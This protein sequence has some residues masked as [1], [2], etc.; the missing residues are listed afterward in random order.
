MS[1]VFHCIK[2]HLF[3]ATIHEFS[4]L[5]KMLILTFNRT[6]CSCLCFFL[7]SRLN[8]SCSS[9]E[10]LSAYKLYG[11]TLTGKYCNSLT[12]L[13]VRL[14]RVLEAT[15]LNIMAWRFTFNGIISVLNFMKTYQL[16]QKLTEGATDRGW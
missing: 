4:P 11:P 8:K 5:N 10:D 16:V 7:K 1:M 14:F 2:H 9:S 3:N 12:S 6:R 15:R 13:N